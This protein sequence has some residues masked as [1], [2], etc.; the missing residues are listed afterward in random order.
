MRTIRR[1]GLLTALAMIGVW[2]FLPMPSNGAII[3]VDELNLTGVEL[4]L[5]VAVSADSSLISIMA[6][7][8]DLELTVTA[9]PIWTGSYR[10]F[11][12]EPQQIMNFG[13]YTGYS[14]YELIPPFT[15][16]AWLM[17][18]YVGSATDSYNAA[19]LQVAIWES[20]LDP[21]PFD[22]TKGNFVLHFGLVPN[23]TRAKE[24]LAALSNAD[25]SSF[26]ATA[27]RI[28]SDDGLGTRSGL[29]DLIVY[30]AAVPIPSGLLL[31]G[32]G[33]IAFIGLR[34]KL[35]SR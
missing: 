15:N 12:V 27:Y 11:C 22:L 17:E 21:K 4:N 28:A 33:L 10:G 1:Y 6:G 5:S 7:F 35:A 9:D 23:T 20:L 14:L 32:S 29:Q 26:D 34:R 19:S 18:T 2:L 8:Y 3:P 13:S 30:N 16:A 25:I 24:M 31:L